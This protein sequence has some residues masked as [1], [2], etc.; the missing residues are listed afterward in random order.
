M[1]ATVSTP[2]PSAL[3]PEVSRGRWIEHW[4][5]EDGGQWAA[6]GRRIARRNLIFSILSEHLAFSVWVIWSILVVALGTLTDSG[7]VA[8]YPDLVANQAN[9][10]KISGWWH[11]LTSSAP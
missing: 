11:F 3:A 10:S 1:T 5:P 6:H 7:G 4:E 2:A 8:L 9:A